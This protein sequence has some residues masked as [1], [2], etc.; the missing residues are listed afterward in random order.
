MVAIYQGQEQE[1]TSSFPRGYPLINNVHAIEAKNEPI[2][3]RKGKYSCIN[4]SLKKCK[5]ILLRDTKQK[6]EDTSTQ[7]YIFNKDGIINQNM[8]MITRIHNSP[9]TKKGV[10][11]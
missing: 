3:L 1:Y 6:E 8:G 9:I 10:S 11:W 2:I 7:K 5:V 4:I